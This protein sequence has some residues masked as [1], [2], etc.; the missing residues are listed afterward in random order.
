MMMRRLATAWNVLTRVAM[1]MAAFALVLH[2]ALQVMAHRAAAAGMQTHHAA[3]ADCPGHVH[4]TIDTAER[5]LL[6][7]QA[8]DA[9]GNS[10]QPPLPMQMDCCTAVA[11]VVLPGLVAAELS[12]PPTARGVAPRLSAILE[13]VPPGGPSEPPRRADQG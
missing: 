9:A 11:A 12:A 8:A 5:H 2:G 6:D 4:G 1:M 3:A 10:D 7:Q 13:G